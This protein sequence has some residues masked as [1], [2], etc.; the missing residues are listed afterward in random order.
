MPSKQLHIGTYS[1]P[2]ATPTPRKDLTNLKKII[3]ENHKLL[4]G[5][6]SHASSAN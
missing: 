4:E 2:R 1:A 3:A 5:D 6:S